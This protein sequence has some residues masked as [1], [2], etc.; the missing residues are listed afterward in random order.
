MVVDF[1][2]LAFADHPSA[3]FG[4]SLESAG[5]SGCSRIAT[6]EHVQYAVAVWLSWVFVSAQPSVLHGAYLLSP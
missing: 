5:W 6:S 4:G 2:T 3:W 1:Q